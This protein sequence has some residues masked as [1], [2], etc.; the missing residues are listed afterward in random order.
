MLV[1]FLITVN[2]NFGSY[3]VLFDMPSV[4]PAAETRFEMLGGTP[5][6]DF[7]NTV[8]GVRSGKHFDH[9]HDYAGLLAWARQGELVTK[10]RARELTAAAKRNP[11]DIA[12]IFSRSIKLREAI[13]GIFSSLATGK[14]APAAALAVLN[15]ELVEAMRNAR[16]VP[17]P[18]RGFDWQLP[19]NVCGLYYPLQAVARDAAEL[20]TSRHLQEVRQ[21]AN[22]SCGWLFLDETRNHSRL[23]C[24]MRA[25][26]NRVKQ[27]RFRDRSARLI[28]GGRRNRKATRP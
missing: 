2:L 19:H 14:P 15:N 13:Y 3:P 16:I 1:T 6:L 24:D 23:W 27:A 8:S 7:T 9:L 10:P 20:L 26:G 22:Q 28:M 21:C 5:C 17:R 25:C 11:R 12:D 4:P 18:S